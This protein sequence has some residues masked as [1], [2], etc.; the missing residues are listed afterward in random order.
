M[1]TSKST[2]AV[3]SRASGSDPMPKLKGQVL[4]AG[5]ND[6]EDLGGPTPTTD[7]ATDDSNKLKQP[8][9]SQTKSVVNDKG[10]GT[11][12]TGGGTSKTSVTSTDYGN[13]KADGTHNGRSNPGPTK[14]KSATYEHTDV[15][16]AA[17]EQLD[18]LSDSQDASAEFKARAKVIFEAALNEKLSLEVARLEEEFSTRFEEEIGEIA[19]KVES[20]LNY[21][22]AQWLEENKLVVENGIRNELAESFVQGL[23]SLFDNHYVTL[24]DE[25]YDIFESMVAKLDDMEEKLNEQIEANIALNSNMS[26]YQRNA[27]LADVSWDLSEVGKDR[28]TSLAEN[29]EFESDDSYRQKLNILKE[30]FLGTTKTEETTG[31]YLEEETETLTLTEEE[32]MSDDVMSAYAKAI[33]RTLR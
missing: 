12:R 1:T 22:S 5:G 2:T 23:K 8:T 10:G 11:Q 30:S 9:V 19:E 7:K 29:V 32:E 4:P 33:S 20:F 26:G 21:T 25:K 17:G 18:E 28:L 15:D 16:D 14:I 31:N 3:N 13:D 27:I 24:P 6:V